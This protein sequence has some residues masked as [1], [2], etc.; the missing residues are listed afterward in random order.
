MQA[1]GAAGE[2]I[3]QAKL[4]LRGWTAGNVNTG[5]MMNA[6]AIDLFA[7]KGSRT[8]RIAV[9]T[10]GHSNANVQ[11]SVPTNWTT[12]FK[13][14]ERP[15]FVI[16]VWFTNPDKVD[17]CRV[18]IV[19]ADEVDETVK[20]GHEEWHRFLRRDGKP[21]KYS[22]HA[23]ITWTGNPNPEGSHQPGYGK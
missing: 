23:A 20:K 19:P 22:N 15:D 12:L 7:A 2:L 5:G 1:I 8:L 17:E 21:R 3:V 6:P 16:F 9:K 11:W 13:G 18:F 14:Q 10:T 4:L